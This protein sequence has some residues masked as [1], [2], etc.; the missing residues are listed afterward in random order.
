MGV[1]LAAGAAASG[2]GPKLPSVNDLLGN[3]KPDREN[4]Q[5]KEQDDLMA[6][7]MGIIDKYLVD[8]GIV[9]FIPQESRPYELRTPE[10]RGEWRAQSGAP[11]S[12][13]GT[14]AK[15]TLSDGVFF[16][17]NSAPAPVTPQS[18]DLPRPVSDPSQYAEP[19]MSSAAPMAPQFGMYQTSQALPMANNSAF[20]E[21]DKRRKA[22]EFNRVK[23]FVYRDGGR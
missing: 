5:I 15:P 10:Q 20:F 23:D 16:N 7:Y 3:E 8:R 22:E 1:P 6:R 18:K 9:N 12:A 17:N 4:Y 19:S 14:I 13:Q 11:V 21:Q 2:K